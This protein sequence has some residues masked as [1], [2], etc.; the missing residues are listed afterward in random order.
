MTA[1]RSAHLVGVGGCGGAF[2]YD[3]PR[4]IWL[5]F[6]M[7]TVVSG[8]AMVLLEIWSSRYWIIELRGIA[9]IA[10]LL[11]LSLAGMF[12]GISAAVFIAAIV[13]SGVFSH[14]PAAVRYFS[15]YHRRRTH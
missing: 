11:L 15:I 2:L 12:D 13:I 4:E 3:G 6:L 7:L 1:L 8:F 14:A 5:P 10:K 9:I